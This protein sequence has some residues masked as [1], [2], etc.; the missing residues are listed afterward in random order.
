VRLSAAARRN[1]AVI[2]PAFNEVE[3]IPELVAELRATFERYDLEGEVVLVDDGS[4][5]GTAQ[6]ARERPRGGTG[7]RW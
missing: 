4:T 1:F 6:R 5:D 2:I 7:S 3:N